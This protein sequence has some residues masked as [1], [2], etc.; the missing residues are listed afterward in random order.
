[1][2]G[3]LLFEV[4]GWVVGEAVG[5]A[6]GALF[7]KRVSGWVVLAACAVTPCVLWA[8]TRW[9][10]ADAASDVRTTLVVLSW[11]FLPA[12]TILLTLQYDGGV[13]ERRRLR[14]ESAGAGVLRNDR[15]RER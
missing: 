4:V 5:E 9:W 15:L 11:M 7:P 2:I 3:E 10:Q 13:Q 12:I 14:R 1:M 8:T 6:F